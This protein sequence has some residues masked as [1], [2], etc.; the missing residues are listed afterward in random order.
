MIKGVSSVL[1]SLFRQGY[2][3]VVSS[4]Q[5]SSSGKVFEEMKEMMPWATNIQVCPA[6]C[7]VTGR[8]AY[9][10]F[11]KVDDD[12]EI[13]IGGSETYEPR[14]WQ[15]HPLMNDSSGFGD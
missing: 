14:C 11:R 10:T 15:H 12:S 3:I 6:V 8:D 7:P 2:N 1:L 9:Y 13:V 5:L 4:L